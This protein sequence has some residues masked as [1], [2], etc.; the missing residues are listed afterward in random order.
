MTLDYDD[1]FKF[2]NTVITNLPKD[3]TFQDVLQYLE[4]NK[5]VVDINFHRETD[6][7]QNQL[8]YSSIKPNT[9]TESVLQEWRRKVEMGDEET[10][11]R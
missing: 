10:D 4:N 2:F 1:D 11:R 9:E 6:W 8:K 7:K 3:F 5:E